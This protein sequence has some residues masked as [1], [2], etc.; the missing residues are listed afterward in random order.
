MFRQTGQDSG[1][2]SCTVPLSSRN[3]ISNPPG[4][5]TEP[6]TCDDANPGVFVTSFQLLRLAVVRPTPSGCV[7]PGAL[8]LESAA[9][10]GEEQSFSPHSAPREHREWGRG[11]S[12]RSSGG[13]STEAPSPTPDLALPA[14]LG[15]PDP[16]TPLCVWCWCERQPLDACPGPMAT[17]LL[18]LYSTCPCSLFRKGDFWA[19]R[20][21]L[22]FSQSYC[23][24]LHYWYHCGVSWFL[25]GRFK[26]P[27]MQQVVL[28]NQRAVAAF[29]QKSKQHVERMSCA[30]I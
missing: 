28:G 2:S 18:D 9:T 1:G 27:E 22:Q 19:R 30:T 12:G 20:L 11:A 8:P 3:E 25:A 6:A 17:H 5:V 26:S 16:E 15:Q 13:C 4:G 23:H 29:S 21:Q 7:G 14:P 24:A 10:S